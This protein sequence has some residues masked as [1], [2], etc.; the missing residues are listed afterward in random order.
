MIIVGRRFAHKEVDETAN[1]LHDLY[2]AIQNGRV[3]LVRQVLA[4]REKNAIRSD[5]SQAA[6]LHQAVRNCD[7]DMVEFFV[8][9]GTDLNRT[10]TDDG[11]METPLG[12]AVKMHCPV[13]M[14]CFQKGGASPNMTD[15]ESK[16]PLYQ[17]AS[18]K[19]SSFEQARMLIEKGANLHAADRQGFTPLHI[20]CRTHRSADKHRLIS[21]LL[22]H[23]ANPNRSSVGGVLCIDIAVQKRDHKTIQMLL[24]AGSVEG[25]DACKL[26]AEIE[27]EIDPERK[28]V[29]QQDPCY[30]VLMKYRA[31]KVQ[32]LGTTSLRRVR[33]L[34]ISRE[35]R[36]GRSIIIAAREL[37][38]P[39]SL[40]KQCEDFVGPD[41]D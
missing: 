17:A 30:Q 27:E 16:T 33:N 34:L 18:K 39:L 3:D 20:A 37:P 7:T 26:M 28:E 40:I 32:S 8:T 2:V 11:K 38:L 19:S 13:V 1:S 41:R 21:L 31:R 22:N 24:E 12:S 10:S 6:A 4:N 15:Y 5:A 14:Y 9:R 29:L 25:P 35:R 23:G 36:A